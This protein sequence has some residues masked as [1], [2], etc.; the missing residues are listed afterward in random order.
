MNA[1]LTTRRKA[2]GYGNGK[3][4]TNVDGNTNTNGNVNNYGFCSK[5]LEPI[6]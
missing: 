6:P 1:L 4:Y 5:R 2:D 3:E